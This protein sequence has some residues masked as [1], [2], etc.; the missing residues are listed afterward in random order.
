MWD[1][2]AFTA[3]TKNKNVNYKKLYEWLDERLGHPHWS[4][5]PDVI[6]GSVAENKNYYYNILFLKNYQLQY[7]ILLLI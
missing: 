3:F 7:G 5:I 2:G 4:V 1:N 6:D